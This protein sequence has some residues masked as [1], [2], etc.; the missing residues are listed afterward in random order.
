MKSDSVWSLV[1]NKEAHVSPTD[2]EF[3]DETKVPPYRGNRVQIYT[4]NHCIRIN[5]SVLLKTIRTS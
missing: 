5:M 1:G 2:F 4:F 3:R